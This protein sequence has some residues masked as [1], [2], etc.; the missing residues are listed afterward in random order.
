MFEVGVKRVK[1][2]IEKRLQALLDQVFGNYEQG[3]VD[4][5]KKIIAKYDRIC[6][7]LSRNL[8]TAKDVLEMEKFKNNLLLEMGRLRGEMQANMES[9][10]FLVKQDRCLTEETR[11][12]VAALHG[13]PAQLDAHM[14]K[15][16]ER[17]DNE[18]MVLEDRITQLRK[19]FL[20]D[21]GAIEGKVREVA[22]WSDPQSFW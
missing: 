11:D 14:Q 15:C 18:R 9:V 20:V 22:A 12:L 8:S 7:N 3:I 17:H 6:E 19:E 2:E 10:L 16:D 1:E 5:S 4:T 13:W 21:L